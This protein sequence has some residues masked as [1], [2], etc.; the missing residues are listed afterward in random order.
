MLHYQKFSGYAARET[1][2]WSTETGS[3]L[4]RSLRAIRCCWNVWSGTL[5]HLGSVDSL[6]VFRGGAT[7]LTEEVPV[8]ASSEGLYF[9]ALTYP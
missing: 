5:G 1:V 2:V 9:G 3:V 6:P 7:A 4:T 8:V